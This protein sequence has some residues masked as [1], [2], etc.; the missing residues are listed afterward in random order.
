METPEQAHHRRRALIALAEQVAHAPLPEQRT[1]GALIA[2]L[3]VVGAVS[4]GVG[5]NMASGASSGST[6]GS[7]TTAAPTLIVDSTGDP[8]GGPAGSTTEPIVVPPSTPPS[9]LPLD[10]FIPVPGQ[11]TRWVVF[12]GGKFHLRGA[13][14][15][16]SV[17]QGVEA[18]VGGLLAPSRVVVEYTVDP[19]APAT[20]DDPVYVPASARF[21]TG[22]A[23][24]G[25]DAQSELPLVW[26][27]L[28]S[29]PATTIEIH[30]NPNSPDLMLDAA[31][32]DVLRRWFTGLGVDP[33]RI[34]VTDLPLY[35]PPVVPADEN[36]IGFAV[37][38]V[39][40]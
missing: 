34:T 20:D 6:A 36:A 31:R 25:A 28:G 10:T 37:H 17:G 22:S 4:I 2:G 26:G 7:A 29:H 30:S 8:A 33:A 1:P 40:G 15:N 13:V 14:P 21:V 3:A 5:V 24:L 23:E 32:V 39:F 9:S 19:S 16:L 38:H 35:G 27:L 11:P 18:T 12:A